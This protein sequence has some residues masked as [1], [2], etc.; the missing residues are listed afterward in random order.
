M[1]QV[2]ISGAGGHLASAVAAAVAAA[3]DLDLTGLYNPSRSGEEVTGVTITGSLGDVEGEVVVEAS[4]DS[5]V[6]GNLEAWRDLGKAA[7]VGTSGFTPE[8]LVQLR[9]MWGTGTPCLVVPNF[10]IG[11]VLMMRFAQ[12]AAGQFEAVE[13]IERH[14]DDKPD[15]PSGT[16]LATAMRINQGGGS[17]AEG[18]EE[19][20]EGA[21]G[22]SVEGVRVHAVRLPGVISQQEVVLSN[23]GEML[24][25]EHL[26]TS[27]QSFAGGALLAIRRV[28]SLDG[29]VH[30]GLDTVL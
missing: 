3:D 6:M 14:H 15:A 16:A 20:V 19:L 10:S 22:A 27:Y 7:V 13:V 2:A 29:G 11:A 4:P 17:S 24:S 8:R 5:V 9:D 23:P 21:R 12:E 26:S 18:S 1:I 30:L 25:I 28:Q